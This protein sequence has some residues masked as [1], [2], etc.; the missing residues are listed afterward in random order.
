MNFFI[1]THFVDWRHPVQMSVIEIAG[2]QFYHNSS[3]TPL[4]TKTLCRSLYQNWWS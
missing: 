2:T 3:V 1:Q 4:K